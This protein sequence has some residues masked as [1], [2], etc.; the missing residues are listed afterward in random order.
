VW[1]LFAH[2][3]LRVLLPDAAVGSRMYGVAWV[4]AD[5]A[6]PGTMVVMAHAFGPLGVRRMVAITVARTAQQNIRVVAWHEYRQ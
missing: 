3:P 1:R 4:T 6:Q 2:A 5:A